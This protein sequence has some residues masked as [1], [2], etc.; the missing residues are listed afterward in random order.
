MNKLLN[1][2]NYL[3]YYYYNS[4][5][6]RNSSISLRPKTKASNLNDYIGN[7]FT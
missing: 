3:Y 6:L 1:N 4:I 7:I 5:D 2:L